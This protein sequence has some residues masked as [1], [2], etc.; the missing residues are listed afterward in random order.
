MLT[1][2]SII[3]SRVARINPYW[4]LFLVSCFLWLVL[5]AIAG[6]TP[7][8]LDV[9]IFRDAGWNLAQS[10]SFT[11]MGLPYVADFQPRLY[12]HY[13][14]MMPLL[15][16]VFSSV[17]PRTA[18]SGEMFNSLVG[19]LAAALVLW[20]ALKQ[21]VKRELRAF[22]CIVIAL[23]PAV[24]I[25]YDRPEALGV[26]LF[27][28]TAVVAWSPKS[29]AA[30][31]GVLVALTFLAHPFAGVLAA[32]W[33]C[34]IILMKGPDEPRGWRE[35]LLQ[36]CTLCAS[37][38]LVIGAVAI[39]YFL[40]DKTALLRFA[41]HAFGVS[42]GLGV[43]RTSLRSHSYY[44]GLAYALGVPSTGGGVV[45]SWVFFGYV[46]SSLLILYWIVRTRSRSEWCVFGTACASMVLAAVL[47]PTQGCY[48][49]LVFFLVPIGMLAAIGRTSVFSAR[50]MALIL[51]VCLWRVPVV[52]R[53]T[54]A[55]VERHHSYLLAQEQPYRLLANLPSRD[56]RVLVD[57]FAY[58]L[59]KPVIHN[60]INP[61]Y[62]FSGEGAPF[63]QI[64]GVIRCYG[65]F[66]GSREMTKPLPEF[67]DR[68]QFREVEAAPD[69]V[70]ITLFGHK[71]V[72]WQDGWGC[73][74][75]VR[76]EGGH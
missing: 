35:F 75:Y 20:L 64:D 25:T 52:L 68:T 54:V 42:S 46:V 3:S 45:A 19:F 74:L 67:L 66:R 1:F 37:A 15:F 16:A 62:H 9:F 30:T 61:Y 29:W 4:A 22:A 48:F 6:P 49:T 11:S 57:T 26:V 7:S 21:P 69:H 27:A 65:D 53:D 51:I 13:T 10:G 12:A 63:E 8:G 44:S 40:L 34:L 14:P 23:F 18:L 17:F 59:Y 50:G 33:A 5:G 55:R 71:I 72:H 41:A 56:S 38:V 43:A 31:V 73:D 70:W 58:D 47:F 2:K 32:M 76:R 28:F 36:F 60:L 24:F 39:S